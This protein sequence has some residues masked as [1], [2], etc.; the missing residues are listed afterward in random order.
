MRQITND[1]E[2]VIETVT[3]YCNMLKRSDNEKAALRALSKFPEDV[4][5]IVVEIIRSYRGRIALVQA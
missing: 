4:L 1:N 5:S 3:R 2:H